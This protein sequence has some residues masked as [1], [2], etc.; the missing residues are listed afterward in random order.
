MAAE[1]LLH[2]M[3]FKYF[4]ESFQTANNHSMNVEGNQYYM[5]QPLLCEKVV[6]KDGCWIGEKVCVL[7]GVTIGEKSIVGA[8]SVVTKSIPDYCLAVG[9][10]ARVIKRWNFSEHRWI[11][12]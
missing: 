10:P 9:N 11:S 5:A 7:P 12:L 6:I 1:C 8:G 4:D 3:Y 2:Q